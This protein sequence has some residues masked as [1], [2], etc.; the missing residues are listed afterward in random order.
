MTVT[1]TPLKFLVQVAYHIQDF[2][3][4]GASGWMESEAYDITAKP[5][6]KADHEEARLMLRSLLAD[7]FHLVVHRETKEMPIY[8][9]VLATFPLK[10]PGVSSVL[11]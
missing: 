7:R 4:S 2:Q 5:S 11:S 1:D 10:I 3:L 9:V 8:A 6:H